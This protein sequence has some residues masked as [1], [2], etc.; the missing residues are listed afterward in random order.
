VAFTKPVPE[1]LLISF[2]VVLSKRAI[3]LSTEEAGPD[4]SPVPAG[5]VKPPAWFKKRVVEDPPEAGTKPLSPE[6]KVFSMAVTC[7]AVRSV[8]LSDP[9]VLLPLIVIVA[10]SAIFA[11]VTASAAIVVA[12]DPEEFVTSP[13]NA[14][15]A[16]VGSV[17]TQFNPVAAPELGVRIVLFAPTGSLASRVEKV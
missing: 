13:V 4:T 11:L 8:G 3:S 6:V 7:V 10:M 15:I 14:G 16:G 17:A 2:P 5:A 9:P 12:R 1:A